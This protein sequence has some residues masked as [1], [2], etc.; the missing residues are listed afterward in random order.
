M[1]NLKIVLVPI[2]FSE[3]SLNAL[4]TG[5]AIAKSENAKLQMLH[6]A[7]SSFDFLSADSQYTGLN[8]MPE[9][10]N[11]I[12]YALASM[13][14]KNHDLI[15][16]VLLFEGP[17]CSTIIK[18][19]W[20]NNVDLIVM[21]T[22]G[23]SGYR[24]SFIGT[25]TY[26]VVK[27]ACCSVLTVPPTGKCKVFEK[28]LI[29]IRPSSTALSSYSF[30]RKLID[31]PNGN[32]E[33]LNIS[34]NKLD[35]QIKLLDKIINET[36]KKFKDDKI[37][38]SDFLSEGKSPAQD[39]LTASEKL[40]TDLIVITPSIDAINKQFYIGPHTQKILHCA[41][42]PLLNIKLMKIPVVV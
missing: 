23:A 20:I 7:D 40:K 36:K 35:N 25:N 14:Q 37:Q 34:T 6:I 8:N 19:A 18:T 15:P 12:M 39:V 27:N 31:L 26:N 28:V 10:S 11:D 3:A 24:D 33:V 42:V 38:G 30:I 1:Y 17:V 21:G 32:M 5:A 41:R 29:P 2:D 4:E 16:D 13:I 22:H 9:S